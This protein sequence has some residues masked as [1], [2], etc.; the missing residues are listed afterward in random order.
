MPVNVITRCGRAGV[1][2]IAAL[3][4]LLQDGRSTERKPLNTQAI[5]GTPLTPG[6]HQWNYRPSV[7]ATRHVLPP[8]TS[9]GEEL[10]S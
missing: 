5:L 9:Q 2:R 7:G 4:S 10:Y 8:P 3:T 1:A 6:G